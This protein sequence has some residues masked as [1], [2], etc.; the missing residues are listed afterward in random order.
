MFTDHLSYQTATHGVQ[1]FVRTANQLGKHQQQAAELQEC[2]SY[3]QLGIDA[4]HWLMRADEH[5]RRA[6]FSQ[7]IVY[8]PAFDQ[9]F[10]AL[11]AEWLKPVL[12]AEG[13]LASLAKRALS[14][15]N[16]IEFRGCV[17]EMRA[18]L[19]ESKELGGEMAVLRDEA[20]RAFRADEGDEWPS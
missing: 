1:A 8:D 7:Q 5:Y 17:E 14:P 13:W 3:L 19:T 10:D 16:A 11:C 4:F 12:A 6:V 18:M 15:P 2:E 20:I 9:A